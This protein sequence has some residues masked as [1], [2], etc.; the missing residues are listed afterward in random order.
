MGREAPADSML[1]RQFCNGCYESF[2]RLI[3]RYERQIFGVARAVLPDPG[4]A[5]GVLAGVFVNLAQRATELLDSTSLEHFLLRTLRDLLIEE[6]EIDPRLLE[7]GRQ[8]VEFSEQH[9]TQSD[10]RLSNLPVHFSFPFVLRHV[11]RKD[12]S[13]IAQII[14]IPPRAAQLRLTRSYRLLKRLSAGDSPQSVWRTAT[15]VDGHI[16]A[17]I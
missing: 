17:D 10:L 4:K 9:T 16:L 3:T 15:S 7:H 6:Q 14:E 2:E 1:L 11:A 13:E 12:I 8:S 5:E